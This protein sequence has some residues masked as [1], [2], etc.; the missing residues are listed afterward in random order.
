MSQIDI[1]QEGVFTHATRAAIQSNFSQLFA[2]LFQVGNI[3]YLDPVTGSDTSGDGTVSK[4][5]AT[6][7]VAYAACA[8]GNNDVVVLVGDGTTTA[9]ARV[10]SAFTWSK[11]ATH[12]LGYA[13]PSLYSQRA[14]I[15]PSST[16][17]AFA[18][19]FTVSGHGCLFS[20]V[21]W[22]AGFT[23]GT[24]SAIAMTVSGSRNVF[25]RCHISG[26]VDAASAANAAS[27]SLKVTGG[28]NLFK[29]CVIGSDTVLRS[30]A[31]A[32]IQFAGNAARTV[33]DH[34]IFPIW[35]SNTAALVANVAA[36]NPNGTDRETIFDYC[37]FLNITGIT[38][39]VTMAAVATSVASGINGYFLM[40]NCVRA[41][42]TDW[43]SDSTTLGLIQVCGPGTGGTA[44][45]DVGR[46]TVAVAS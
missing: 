8:D 36:A 40:N 17:T 28:E 32:T 33:F 31:N 44:G 42:I 35:T 38:S 6:L 9:T 45:D 19:F 5:Y 15:A 1:T 30:A 14:R 2:G 25:S 34:C 18:N 41:G 43:G 23:T 26:C 11:S 7:A 22:Y 4:P 16:A 27:C 29:E 46:A 21:A 20:N 13:A 39:A 3:Y 10:D 12:L 24:T 37:R